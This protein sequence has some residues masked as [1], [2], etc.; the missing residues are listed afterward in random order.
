MTPEAAVARIRSRRPTV[1]V[2]GDFLLDGWWT[3]STERIAREAPAAVVDILEQRHAP[4]GA[5]N[6]ALNLAGLGAR[7]RAVGIV[8]GDEAG[9]RLR[10]HLAGAGVDVTRVQVIP[11][12]RTTTKVR[13]SVD[14]QVLVRL[15]STER[16]PW[17]EAALRA[18][19]DET[20]ASSSDSDAVVICDYGSAVLTDAV[21][22]RLSRAPRP[23]LLV[24]DA[25]EPARWRPL[26]PDVAT[27]NA[28]EA[29]S[30]LPRSLGGGEDRV[31]AATRFSDELLR[32]S[33]AS[34]LVVTLDQS[35]T[36]LL[37]PGRPPHRTRARAVPERQASGAGDV[38]TAGLTVAAASG[39]PLDAA[40]EFAQ[41]AA[42]VA[43][44]SSHTCVCSLDEVEADTDGSDGRVLTVEVLDARLR[45]HRAR[46]ERIVFTNGCFDVLHRGHT[47]SLRQ[48]GQ[49]GDVLVVALNSDTSA[50]RLKGP[51]R[52]VNAEADRASVIAELSCVDY[53]IVFDEDT[54]DAL[55]RRIRPDVYAKGGDYTPEMLSES[56]VVR[57]LGGEVVILDYVPDHSTTE[58]IGRI[59]DVDRRSAGEETAQSEAG[60]R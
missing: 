38:F 29:E 37:R 8:G 17:P 40:V 24:V 28:R 6:T 35:G 25:H 4:G 23:P 26:A 33:G 20:V 2:L 11:H 34:A 15:D 43:V 13:V 41:R 52:P 9:E 7:V 21:I 14:E 16:R 36:V 10:A 31:T 27:P 19:V 54:P 59:R 55:L 47:A 44:R 45:E 42:D 57:A 1:T 51:D 46:G 30:L 3:G 5:A 32:A 49:L 39:L 60:A 22:S 18:L 50:R 48:A 58:I 12:A 53:V 56:A